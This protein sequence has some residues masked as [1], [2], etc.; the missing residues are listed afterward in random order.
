MQTED[1]LLVRAPGRAAG[2]YICA[3]CYE[4]KAMQDNGMKCPTPAPSSY[5]AHLLKL[6]NLA[7]K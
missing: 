3:D 4:I 5:L 2:F 7:P 1:M 6:D